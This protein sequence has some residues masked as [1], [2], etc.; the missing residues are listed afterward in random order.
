VPDQP[1]ATRTEPAD[2]L[3]DNPLDDDG[4]DQEPELVLGDVPGGDLEFLLVPLLGEAERQMR[5][6]RRPF[7]AELWAS[8]LLGMLDLGAPEG[9]TAEER[10]AVTLNLATR[11]IEYAVEQNS[12]SGLA[13]LRTLSV[14]GPPQSRTLAQQEAARSGLRDRAWAATVGR[15][16]VRRSWR[17]RDPAGIQESVTVVF[18]Y[19]KREHALTV[20]IDQELGGGVKHCWISDDPDGVLA[21]ARAA[22]EPD[23]IEVE[24]ISAGQARTVLE[25]ALTRPECPQSP[26]E[27]EDLAMCRAFLQARVDLLIATCI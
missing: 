9:S 18:G 21:E 19:G 10:E 7:D 2:P 16:D 8:E 6:I 3:D 12:L 27:I 4:P 11:L 17:F 15:P 14:I 20:L 25:T 24:L 26:E 23:D 22:L 5:S 1:D 13:M